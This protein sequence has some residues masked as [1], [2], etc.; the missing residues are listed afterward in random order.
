LQRHRLVH[1]GGTFEPQVIRKRQR[2]LNDVDEVVVSVYAKGLTSR[3]ISAHLAGIYGASVSKGPLY[4]RADTVTWLT[5]P[6]AR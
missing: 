1:A 6:S 2:R 5:D 4:C 3:E